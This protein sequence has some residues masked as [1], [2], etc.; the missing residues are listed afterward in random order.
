VGVF[1]AGPVQTVAASPARVL[2]FCLAREPT[3][4]PAAVQPSLPPSYVGRGVVV[5]RGPVNCAKVLEHAFSDRCCREIECSYANLVARLRSPL[6]VSSHEELSCT[7]RHVLWP[8]VGRRR[9]ES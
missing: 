4:D 1:V 5:A 9:P 6:D 3:T 7:D 2:P 8:R